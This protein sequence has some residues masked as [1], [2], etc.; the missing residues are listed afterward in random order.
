MSVLVVWRNIV[1]GRV[2]SVYMASDSRFSFGQHHFDHGKKVFACKNDASLFGYCGGVEYATYII[3]SVV[4]LIEA[5]VLYKKNDTCEERIK[6]VA[7]KI[8]KLWGHFIGIVSACTTTIIYCTTESSTKKSRI[9]KI[10]ISEKG[11]CSYKEL[12]CEDIKSNNSTDFIQYCVIGSGK[13]AFNKEYARYKG[14]CT[15]EKNKFAYITSRVMFQVLSKIIKE[16]NSKND[17]G[18]FPQLAYIYN[19]RRSRTKLCG[20]IYNDECYLGGC[21]VEIAINNDFAD[22]LKWYNENFELCN[23]HT[24]KKKEGT[25][26]Q[27]YI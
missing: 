3:Q 21:S 8:E 2:T 6:I 26:V 15:D 1:N 23:P 16:A 13:E 14:L 11:Q 5:G 7:D 4:D 19:N 25:Q 27:P 10:S 24:K 20:V 18:G 22:T 17:Y 12:D 9:Y